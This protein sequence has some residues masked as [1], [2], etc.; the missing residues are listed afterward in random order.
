[1]GKIVECTGTYSSGWQPVLV[2]DNS[3][4]KLAECRVGNS[5]LEKNLLDMKTTAAM[6]HREVYSTN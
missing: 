6:F 3:E 5:T 2:K 4:F 1:M